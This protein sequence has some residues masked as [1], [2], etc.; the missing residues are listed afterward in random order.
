[1]AVLSAHRDWCRMSKTH[2]VGGC[3]RG[4]DIIFGGWIRAERGKWA[5]TCVYYDFL[6]L[7]TPKNQ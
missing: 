1:M 4:D 6:P 7:K 3:N 2:D 5:D